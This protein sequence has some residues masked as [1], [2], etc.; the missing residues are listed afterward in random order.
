MS[1]IVDPGMRECVI[2]RDIIALRRL[3][4]LLDTRKVQHFNNFNMSSFQEPRR[5]VNRYRSVIAEESNAQDNVMPQ[6]DDV[7]V[8]DA[9][10]N[11]T[12]SRNTF[13]LFA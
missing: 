3:L 7:P 1:C 11:R 6:Q 5:A 4:V 8:R 2:V 9:V 10:E 12:V 13:V